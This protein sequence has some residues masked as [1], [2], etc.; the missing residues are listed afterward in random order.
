MLEGA[1][2]HNQWFAGLGG[3]GGSR[4]KELEGM[5]TSALK[6]RAEALGVH[7]SKIDDALDADSPKVPD[8]TYT[9]LIPPL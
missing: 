2:S 6:N 4:K 1:V 8:C 9:P 3:L 5:K 7:K